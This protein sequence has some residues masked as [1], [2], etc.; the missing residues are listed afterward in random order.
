MA[1]QPYLTS[2][3]FLSV[4]EPEFLRNIN[5]AMKSNHQFGSGSYDIYNYSVSI[6]DFLRN[7]QY[8]VDITGFINITQVKNIPMVV[9]YPYFLQ[10]PGTSYSKI[11][12]NGSSP[13]TFHKLAHPGSFMVEKLTGLTFNYSKNYQVIQISDF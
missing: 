2:G 13:S 6:G 4:F 9:S 3:Q 12:I 10:C 1:F 5:Y 8:Q 11:R 7:P